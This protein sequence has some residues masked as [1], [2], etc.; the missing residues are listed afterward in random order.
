MREWIERLARWWRGETRAAAGWNPNRV[1][2]PAAAQYAT[3]LFA[4][5]SMSFSARDVTRSGD[6]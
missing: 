2:T 5:S 6:R 3:V 1:G 4:T